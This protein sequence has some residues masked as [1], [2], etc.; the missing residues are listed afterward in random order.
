MLGSIQS[1][2]VWGSVKVLYLG[3][4]LIFLYTIALGILQ[5]A[6]DPETPIAHAQLLSHF[7]AGSIGWV[8]LSVMATSLWLYCSHPSKARSVPVTRGF[9]QATTV[10]AWGSVL[11]A[12]AYVV[13]FWLAFEDGGETRLLPAFGIPLALAIWTTLGLV[14][15]RVKQQDP[16]TAPH[17]LLLG[18]LFVV[19]LGALMGVLLGLSYAFDLNIFPDNEAAV[20]VGSHAGP[21]DMYIALAFAALA[22]LLL[23]KGD[24]PRRSKAAVWQA[25]LGV[26]AAVVILV[27]LFVGVEPAPGI[28]F[29]LFVAAFVIFMVRVGWRALLHKPTGPEGPALPVAALSFVVYVVVFTLLVFKY[30]LADK[31][32]PT[33]LLV[34]FQHVTFVGLGTNLLLATHGRF[35]SLT[36]RFGLKWQSLAMWLLNVGLLA[37]VASELL[38]GRREGAFLMALGTLAAWII[39][40]GRTWESHHAITA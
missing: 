32:P 28:A 19:S 29:L 26:V 13:A 8:T 39:V 31:D 34:T 24:H 27:G 5:A 21:M 16:L 4:A 33:A 30:F 18:A 15:S 14:A 25:S 9:E 10:V 20:P 40:A 35:G 36:S 1:R 2:R 17:I 7:H 11:A 37:F 22:E 3:S 23:R 38:A 6:A 12:A